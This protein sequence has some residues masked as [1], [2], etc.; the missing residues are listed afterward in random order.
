MTSNDLREW[1]HEI[2]DA[3]VLLDCK[4][5]PANRLNIVHTIGGSV[6]DLDRRLMKMREHG[7]LQYHPTR[8]ELHGLY[9][10]PQ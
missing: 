9:E 6:D 10:V 5:I 7:K 4:G 2:Q 3:I 8:T 1:E